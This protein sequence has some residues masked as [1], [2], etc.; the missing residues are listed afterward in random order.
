MARVRIALPKQ[1]LFT[2]EM[3]LRISDINYGGHLGNDSVLSIVHEAR[4]RFL[5]SLGLSELD[6]GDS[7][8][9][10]MGDVAAMYLAE[11]FYGD[12]IE[13]SVGSDDFTA[14]SFDLIFSLRNKRTAQEIARVKT[15]ML[16]FNY[17]ERKVCDL[18][19]SFLVKVRA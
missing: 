4:V 5:K 6:I 15:G 7:V 11:G 10:I 19:P 2:T 1:F 14:R 9:L 17:S 18:P 16:G 13:I 12:L 3:P 8:A